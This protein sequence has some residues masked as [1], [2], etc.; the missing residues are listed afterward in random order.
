MR[1]NKKKKKD[2]SERIAQEYIGRNDFDGNKGFQR[3]EDVRSNGTIYGVD[4]IINKSAQEE[5]SRKRLFL[6]LMIHRIT[7][8]RS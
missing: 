4:G 1:T 3:P 7:F 2:N 5:I 6:K 8:A